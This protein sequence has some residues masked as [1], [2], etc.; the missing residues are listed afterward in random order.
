MTTYIPRHEEAA[1]HRHAL[2]TKL[3][4]CTGVASAMSLYDALHGY[5]WAGV[6][7]FANLFGYG[8]ARDKNVASVTVYAG[9][10]FWMFVDH[11]RLM[12]HYY[13]LKEGTPVEQYNAQF[14]TFDHA[15][16]ATLYAC[17]LFFSLFFVGATV[18]F[19]MTGER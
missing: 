15:I 19:W 6:F 18:D 14:Q 5:V 11:V 4:F 3:R 7:F 1:R 9:I 12:V 13:T 10:A 16:Q 17:A 2:V 8:A